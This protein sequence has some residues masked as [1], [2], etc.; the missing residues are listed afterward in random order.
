VE[1]V[2]GDSAR[3]L[4]LWL[5]IAEAEEEEM[6][7]GVED[8]GEAVDVAGAVFIGEDVEEAAVD[9]GVEFL[10][11]LIEGEGVFDEELGGEVALLG[12]ELGAADGFFEKVDAGDLVTFGGEEKS[13]VAGAAAGIEDGAFGKI[14]GGGDGGLGAADVPG[15]LAGIDFLESGLIGEG[16]HC[17]LLFGLYGRVRLDI[18]RRQ[19]VN[20]WRPGRVKKR[21]SKGSSATQCERG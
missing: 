16:A 6:A 15:G 10:V 4:A 7:G 9:D 2:A 13:G 12:F 5:F 14:G 21:I 1:I 11:P 17:A 18:F 19:G 8:V 3:A 20:S